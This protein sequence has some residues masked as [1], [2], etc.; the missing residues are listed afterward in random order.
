MSITNRIDRVTKITPEFFAPK[1]P[2]PHSVKI[3]LTGRCQYRCNFCALRTRDAQPTSDMDFE[4][5]KRITTQ[6][7]DAGVEEIGCFYLGEP[8][9]A[10]GLLVGAIR[11]CKQELEFPYV[12]VTTNGALAAPRWVKAC[13]EAGLDSLK[14]SIN[15][16]DDEQF[17]KVMG[18]KSKNYHKAL[19]HIRLAR[20]IRD[21]SGYKCGIYASSIRY[22]GEQQERMQALLDEHVLPFVDEHYLLP[23]YSMAMR[24]AEI[25]KKLGYK[26]THGN[27]G[28][29]DTKT[30]LPTRDPLPCWAIFTEGHVRC[31]GHLSACCFGSDDKFDIGDLNTQSFMEAW[32]SEKMQAVRAAHIKAKTE[33][34][35]AL[36]GTFCEVC[37]AYQ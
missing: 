8:F 13:M 1:L 12:F 6:M 26:P 7:R 37:V 11:W 16:S 10:P 35:S 5:F 36:K 20:E 33:G 9:M 21:A 15:A 18:V 23:L 17:E 24:S 19:E 30:G 14:F 32:N 29:F 27:S 28:R 4:T 22:D 2:A 31:D 34:P 25:E 3:E